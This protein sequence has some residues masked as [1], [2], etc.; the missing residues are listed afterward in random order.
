MGPSRNYR[1]PWREG[2]HFESLADSTEFFPR[3]LDA[4]D[5]ARQYLLLEMY[6]V[7]SGAVADRFITALLKAAERGVRVHLLLDDFG[8]QRLG[9]RDREQSLG[10]LQ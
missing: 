7:T 6:L 1:F 9:Q 5:S 2:N 4:I 8:T 3:M 10:F